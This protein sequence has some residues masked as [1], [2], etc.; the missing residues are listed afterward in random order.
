MTKYLHDT[1]GMNSGPR[2]IDV[3]GNPHMQYYS[4]LLSGMDYAGGLCT[5]KA[6][7]H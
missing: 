1:R 6:H 5:L 2:F 4:D 7:T 3:Q